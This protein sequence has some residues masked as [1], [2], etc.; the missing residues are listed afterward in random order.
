MFLTALLLA[1]FDAFLTIGNERANHGG[2]GVHRLLHAIR[3]GGALRLGEHALADRLLLQFASCRHEPLLAC[4]HCAGSG[5]LTR[6][7]LQVAMIVFAGN[8]LAH[9]HDFGVQVSAEE[10]HIVHNPDEQ[11]HHNHTTN[12]AVGGV[13]LAEVVGVDGEAETAQAHAEER[14]RRTGGEL[15]LFESAHVRGCRVEQGN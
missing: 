12:K 5:S 10:Q 13:V 4:L 9:E 2:V 7:N 14:Q 6:L 1:V 8:D 11:Q 15:P 3:N